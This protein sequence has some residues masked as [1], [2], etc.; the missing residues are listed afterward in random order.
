M[1]L[2]QRQTM[3]TTV[4][5]LLSLIYLFWG[6]QIARQIWGG[7]RGWQGGAFTQNEKRMAEQAS[8]FL[9]V[10]VGVFFHELAHALSIWLFGG[11]VAEFGYRVF[12][13]FVRPTADSVFSPQQNWFIALAGTLG[14]LAFGFILWFALRNHPLPALR[15]FGLRAFRYQIFF[16]LVY[17]PIFTV[18]G[19]YGDWRVIY[20]DFRFDT[21][22]ILSGLTLAVHIALL[23]W[24]FYANRIGWF[25]MP[26][27]N[28]LAEQEQLRAL[29]RR[30]AANPQD[31]KLQLQLIDKY[32]QHGEKNKARNHLR[33]FLKENP[34]S[35]QGYLLS[36][37][38]KAQ[39]KQQ[40]PKGAKEDAAKALSLGL[41]NPDGIAYANQL[42]GEYSLGV[43]RLDQAIDYFN[44]GIEALSA[45]EQPG[46][47]ARLYHG[48]AIAHRRNGQYNMAREDIETAIELARSSGQ[49]QA[50]SH[51]QSE[52]ATIEQQDTQ[53][54]GLSSNDRF[55][56]V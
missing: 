25:E 53:S 4:F 9:A 2:R 14:S 1:I 43:G 10:P 49:S 34:R 22:P 50:M 55:R 33:A 28:S 5:N 51:Y 12:W 19:F 54:K 36:A 11:G 52:L 15:Y 35:A 46:L 56:Q 18:I 40:I 20:D 23:G 6:L 8:F 30:A 29:E 17:Y 48:R 7:R 27:F 3:V 13:G 39:D 41:D 31:N 44:Q 32:R 47:I 38:L 45:D 37:A 42:Q 26:T 21:T 16:S 24:F